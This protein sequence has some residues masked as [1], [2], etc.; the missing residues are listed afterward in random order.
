MW[1]KDRDHLGTTILIQDEMT[2]F[3]G[4]G[5]EESIKSQAYFEDRV[6]RILPMDNI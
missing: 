6:M 2:V 5:S 1:L 3:K 4:Q